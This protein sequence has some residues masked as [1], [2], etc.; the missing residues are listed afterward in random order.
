V[1][2]VRK[3]VTQKAMEPFGLALESFYN[4]NEEAKVIYRRDDGQYT[5][6]SIKG[7]F[8]TYSDFTEREKIAIS[9]CQ[10]QILDIGAGVGPHSLELQKNEDLLL[11]QYLKFVLGID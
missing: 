6:D 5:E 8:R 11:L 3:S 2:N 7:Y 10:G 1:K 9:Q 4:G